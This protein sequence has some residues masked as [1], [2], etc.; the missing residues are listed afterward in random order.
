MGQPFFGDDAGSWCRESQ[1]STG[2]GFVL[3]RGTYVYG[4]STSCEDLLTSG[5]TFDNLLPGIWRVGIALNGAADAGADAG[6]T[7]PFC[8]VYYGEAIGLAAG[9]TL[10]ANVPLPASSDRNAFDCEK[11]ALCADGIDNDENDFIDCAD[12]QCATEC[13]GGAAGDA[14]TVEPRDG[15]TGDGELGDSGASDGGARSE[16]GETGG[17]ADQ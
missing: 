17:N 6:I 7:V 1:A 5:V 13:D 12:P 3:E 11:G 15:D 8:H 10:A 9:T 14:A 4:D 2:R 16:G